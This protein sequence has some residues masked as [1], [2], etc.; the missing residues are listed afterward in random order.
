MEEVLT[1]TP[2]SLKSFMKRFSDLGFCYTYNFFRRNFLPLLH[3]ASFALAM[4]LKRI[5]KSTSEL[6][7]SASMNILSTDPDLYTNKTGT[8][9]NFV[10]IEH[11]IWM[12]SKDILFTAIFLFCLE[13]IEKSLDMSKFS[14]AQWSKIIKSRERRSTIA[15][16]IINQRFEKTGVA[17]F[18]ISRPFRGYEP[19]FSR[20]CLIQIMDRKK[21]TFLQIFLE[22]KSY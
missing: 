16:R 7:E 10:D 22:E 13:Y 17:F 6:L 1:P 11:I 12:K 19:L 18:H 14:L 8:I 2:K 3:V 15:R 4:Q 20:I 21:G 9:E 5:K